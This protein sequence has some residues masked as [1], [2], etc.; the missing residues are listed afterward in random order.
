MGGGSH[1]NMGTLTSFPKHTQAHVS[2]TLKSCITTWEC[3][4]CQ[5]SWLINRQ[6]AGQRIKASVDS[7]MS[8]GLKHSSWISFGRSGQW[9]EVTSTYSNAALT[10]LTVSCC[11]VLVVLSI[12]SMP[13]SIAV[14]L[15][16]VNSVCIVLLL[17]FGWGTTPGRIGRNE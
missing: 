16:I 10:L 13:F 1:H 6:L 9:W 17:L 12:N 11:Y 15:I 2:I 7:V 3:N 4:R 5:L 8:R 14:P